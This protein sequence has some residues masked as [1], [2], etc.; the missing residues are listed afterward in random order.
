[1]MCKWRGRAG[2]RHPRV[3]GDRGGRLRTA[4]LVGRLYA[5]CFLGSASLRANAVGSLSASSSSEAAGLEAGVS[6]AA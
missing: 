2:G 6:Q 4:S 5:V 1:M 3:G